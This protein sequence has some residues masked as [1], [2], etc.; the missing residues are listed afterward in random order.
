MAA[1]EPD[2]EDGLSWMESLGE[3]L[4]GERKGAE[5]LEHCCCQG[6]IQWKVGDGAVA[7]DW[8]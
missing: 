1:R 7:L 4:G 8:P 5:I 2:C 3:E 6:M